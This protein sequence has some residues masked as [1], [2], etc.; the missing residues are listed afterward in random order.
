M[1][2]LIGDVYRSPYSPPHPSPPMFEGETW[3]VNGSGM[4]LFGTVN[5]T[6]KGSHYQEMKSIH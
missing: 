6:E 2:I 1:T 4:E 5:S 3:E